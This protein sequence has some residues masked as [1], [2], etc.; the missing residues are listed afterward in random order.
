M[1]TGRIAERIA[2]PEKTNEIHQV[3]AEGGHYGMFTFD[4][5]MLALV[6]AGRIPVGSLKASTAP[7]DLAAHAAAGGRGR[8]IRDLTYQPP[9]ATARN[10]PARPLSAIVA[11]G[12]PSVAAR[13]AVARSATCPPAAAGLDGGGTVTPKELAARGPFASPTSTAPDIPGCR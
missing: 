4:Q 1:N 11:H 2:D 9:A 3:I 8:P 5:P 7:N 10:A 12:V 6:R 13:G